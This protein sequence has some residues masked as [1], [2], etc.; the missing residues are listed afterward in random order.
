MRHSYLT[1]LLYSLIPSSWYSQKEET[2]DFLLGALATD[3]RE[4]FNSG[5]VV[6]AP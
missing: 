4:G 5:I 1:R 3:L 2:L 6:N